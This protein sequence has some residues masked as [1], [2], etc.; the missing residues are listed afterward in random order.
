MALVL[1]FALH[2]VLSIAGF[3]LLWRRIESLEAELS[4]F[5]AGSSEARPEHALVRAARAW[6]ERAEAVA[7]HLRGPTLSPET[8]RGL[9]LAL[10]A[11]SPA[12]AFFFNADHAAI[13]ASGLAIAAAMMIIALRP[14]WRAAAWAAVLTAS[15]WAL[16]GFALG[17]AQADPASYSIFVA[18]AAITG[19]V[20]AHL[21]RAA[22]GATMALAMAAAALALASQTGMV[23]APGVAFGVIAAV[24]AIIGA[25]SLRLEAMHLAAFAAAVIGLFVLSGQPSA[26]IWFTPAAAWAGAL[27][28]AIAAVRVPQLGPRGVALAGTGAFAPLGAIAA[29]NAAQHGLANPLAAAG[30]FLGLALLLAGVVTQAALR[31]GRGL[32]GLRATLWVLVVG[33]FIAVSAAIALALPVQLA[34]PASAALALGLVALDERLRNDVW[35][36]FAIFAGLSALVFAGLA[37]RAVLSETATWSP[38]LA[39]ATGVAATAAL[40]GSAAFVLTRNWFAR[41]AAFFELIA[42]GLAVAAAS[43]WVRVAFADGAPVLRPVTFVE[44]GTH[45]AIWLAAAL[46]IGWRAKLGAESA[47]E[48]AMRAL[49][50]SALAVLTISAGVHAAALVQPLDTDVLA[51]ASVGFALPATLFWGHWAFWRAR[52]DEGEAR[53]ALCAAAVATAT[54]L[55]IEA[56]HADSWPAWARAAAIALSIGAAIGVNFA[57]GVTRPAP[58]VRLP[59]KSPSRVAPQ[60]AHSDAA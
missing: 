39:I 56:A 29:L 16:V 22:P 27:F 28:L 50:V 26:A 42:M 44:A 45:A 7:G 1:F 37:A 36:I 6:G 35:R 25:M 14:I 53:L 41:T 51:R 32:E 47:R 21:R 31:V 52:R 34:A 3:A 2:V 9:V 46:I 24:A 38:W 30:A 4:A 15:A 58:P 57:P 43:L 54:F 10:M 5:R 23:G 20:H 12:I 49:G 18:F 55:I 48:F 17:A 11:T 60:A 13:V 33:A 8:G 40:A 59:E 19:I